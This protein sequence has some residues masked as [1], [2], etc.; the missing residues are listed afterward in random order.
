MLAVIAGVLAPSLGVIALHAG[1]VV[2][3]GRAILLAAP[4]GAGKSTI[5]LALALRGWSLLSDDWTFVADAANGL[6]VWGMQ[7]S[8][9]LLPDAKVYFPSCPPCHPASL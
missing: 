3:D 1:C 7:T 9:K 2:R 5:S 8:I 6:S 4:S